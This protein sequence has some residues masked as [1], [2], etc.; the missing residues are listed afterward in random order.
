[1]PEL[2]NLLTPEFSFRI[3]DWLTLALDSDPI[4]ALALDSDPISALRGTKPSGLN[5]EIDIGA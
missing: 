2:T 1:V 4:S 3:T 5:W